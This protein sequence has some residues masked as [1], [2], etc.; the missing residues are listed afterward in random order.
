MSV[1]WWRWANGTVSSGT[2]GSVTGIA[3]ILSWPTLGVDLLTIAGHKLYA[4][5]GV[6]A[7][8]VRSDIPLEPLIHGAGTRLGAAPAPRAR[9]LPSPWARPARSVA[10]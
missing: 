7:L 4:P 5:K 1:R 3:P 10:T 6:G 2:M 8:Y 9:S